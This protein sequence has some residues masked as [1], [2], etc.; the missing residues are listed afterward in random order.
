MMW[1]YIGTAI[2]LIVIAV[3]YFS[4]SYAQ[5]ILATQVGP[6]ELASANTAIDDKDAQPF[7]T[8]PDGSFSAFV[9]LNP[10]NRTGSYSACGTAPNQAS[11][12]DGTF[13]PCACNATTGDCADCK[14][15]GYTNVF[16]IGGLVTLEVLIA[17]DASRQGKAMAQ[18]LVKTQGPPLTAAA[19]A[20]QSYIETLMLP[21][22]PLQ[23][24]TMVTVAREARRFDVYYNDTLVLSKKTMQMPMN[25]ISNSDFRGVVS[26]SAGLSGQ[27]ALLNIYNYRL[28]SQEVATKFAA[29]ADTRGR[30]YLKT[31]AQDVWGMVPTVAPGGMSI[32]LNDYLPDLS[33]CPSGSCFTGPVVKA[34]SPLYTW[35]SSY[36]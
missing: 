21:P 33:L 16:S 7:N 9:Y 6:F 26:G 24:W 29:S 23:K 13:G 1:V 14:H 17:P 28:S 18:L 12:S 3:F 30:P 5:K 8:G 11:C 10:M 32:T 35:A 2:L 36:A 20:P 31:V 15:A 22:I 27:L 19:T 4:P 25:N 34:A